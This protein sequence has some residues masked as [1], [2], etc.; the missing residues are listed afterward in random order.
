MNPIGTELGERIEARSAIVG[1]IGL[2]YVG[3]P[4][5]V[6]FAEA[7][8]P[9]IGV[10]ADPNRVERLSRGSS[11]VEDVPDHVLA[12]LVQDK[13]LIVGGSAEAR[14]DSALQVQ[15]ARHH[16]HRGGGRRRRP[17]P[18]SGTA[19]GAGVHDVS[20]DDRRG[21]AAALRRIGHGRRR[22]FLPSVFSRARRLGQRDL[23][24]LPHSEGRGRRHAGLP[25]AGLA[26]LRAD[27][28]PRGAGL[29]HADR[30]DGSF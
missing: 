4:L 18:P 29:E 21:A 5:A 23:A 2:G 9:M 15:G 1:V 6:A 26:P 7:G 22:A 17:H 11:P 14:A 25:R 20:R 19:R 13:R 3:L 28:R 16:A 10:D 30:G 12:R 24:P 27:R 8:F